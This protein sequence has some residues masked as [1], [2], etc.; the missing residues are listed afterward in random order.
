MLA[1]L[2]KY[3][4][5]LIGGILGAIAGFAYYEYIGCASGTCPIT[6][7]PYTSTIYGIIIGALLLNTIEK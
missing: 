7:N 5:T 3:K 1:F 6:S 2:M 4:L